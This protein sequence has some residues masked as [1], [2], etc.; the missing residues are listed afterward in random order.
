MSRMTEG[1]AGDLK[2]RLFAV[3][4]PFLVT[5]LL[6]Q[7]SKYLIRTRPDLQRMDLIE[8]VFRFHYTLNPGMA[9]G[10]EWFST[11]VISSFAILATLA[12]SGYV[13]W[14]MDRAT[15]GYLVCMGFVLGGATGNIIDRL[16]LGIIEGYGG[17]LDGHVVDFL[18]ISLMIGD[19]PVF[20][21]IFNVA[22]MG[23]SISIV[24]MILFHRRLI[25]AEPWGGDA[26]DAA[27]H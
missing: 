11:P 1:F 2:T 22:D 27:P 20:P 19:T 25:P 16:F 6:D 15:I 26:E 17:V 7:A 24:T 13:F 5:V 3:S 23:I 12:I 4:I 8:G 14:T 21:Y 18:H 10:I 9:L